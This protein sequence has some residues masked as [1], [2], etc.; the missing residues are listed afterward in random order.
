MCVSVC[1]SVCVSVF[2]PVYIYMYV[3]ITYHTEE[4]IGKFS[5]LDFLE[6]KS[7]VMA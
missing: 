5:F 6:E 4:N 7:L 3:R 2:V 1:L